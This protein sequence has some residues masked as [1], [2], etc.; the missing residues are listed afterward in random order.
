[1]VLAH[2]EGGDGAIFYF[3]LVLL[4]IYTCRIYR[5]Y[6]RV[7]M[8]CKTLKKYKRIQTCRIDMMLKMTPLGQNDASRSSIYATPRASAPS[9][10]GWRALATQ[11][12]QLPRYP[13]IRGTEMASTLPL[14]RPSCISAER[15]ICRK[16]LRGEE[17]AH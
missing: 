12:L 3:Q 6:C 2:F 4:L 16:Y 15:E 9:L 1:M 17:R 5:L 7:R 8:R 14:F 10:N 13:A 11:A